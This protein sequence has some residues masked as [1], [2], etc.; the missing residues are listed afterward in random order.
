MLFKF[1][2]G[3]NT[4]QQPRLSGEFSYLL[5][6]YKMDGLQGKDM[7]MEG[8]SSRRGGPGVEKGLRERKDKDR[9]ERMRIYTKEATITVDLAEVPDGKA[10]DVIKVLTE[11]VGLDQILAVRPKRNK[12]YEMTLA[13]EETCD[14]LLN[15]L[16]IKGKMCEVK[17]LKDRVFV[18]SL[19]HLPA[20]LEDSIIV[21]KLEGW[22]VVPISQIKRRV[23]PGS[24]IEDGTRFAK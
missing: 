7:D 19:M 24:A 17:K 21:D 12:E 3:L 9:T 11:Q 22:G 4:S 15:G 5:F 8:G 18:V 2:F 1:F 23:Y 13:T 10:E 20:Y 16:E 14:E 6:F